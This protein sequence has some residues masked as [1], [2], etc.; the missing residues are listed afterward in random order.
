MQP[1]SAKA[2]YFA[3]AIATTLLLPQAASAAGIKSALD[4]HDILVHVWPTAGERITVYGRLDDV[5]PRQLNQVR[6][7]YMPI[8]GGQIPFDIKAVQ[9]AFGHEELSCQLIGPEHRPVD[10]S[11]F[12][13]HTQTRKYLGS[14]AKHAHY[15]Y[16]RT[17]DRTRYDV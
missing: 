11:K 3:T 10:V 17:P 12:F 5:H 7:S 15:I 2:L 16:C 6:M 14:I 8:Q 13:T 9:L 4:D 1:L